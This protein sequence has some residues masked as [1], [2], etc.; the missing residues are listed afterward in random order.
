MVLPFDVRSTS[1]P[2]GGGSDGQVNCL[3]LID[4]RQLQVDVKVLFFS[5]MI[6]TP[7]LIQLPG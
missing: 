5:A 1:R 4:G 3:R 7:T 6:I 2:T